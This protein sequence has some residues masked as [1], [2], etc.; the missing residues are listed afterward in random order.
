MCKQ[1]GVSHKFASPYHPHVNLA[2]RVNRNLKKMIA[3]YIE[4]NHKLWD[5]YLQKFAFALKSSVNESTKVSLAFL[6]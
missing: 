1:W 4:D 2:E 3:A 5:V 6:I